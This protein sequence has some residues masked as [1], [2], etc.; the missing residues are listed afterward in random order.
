MWTEKY[1]ISRFSN[2]DWA[3]C[4]ATTGE[5]LA[6]DISLS[7]LLMSFAIEVCGKPNLDN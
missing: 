4:S 7:G 3:V 2:G 6:N 5:V 1:I